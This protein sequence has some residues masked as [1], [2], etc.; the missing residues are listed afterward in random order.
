MLRTYSSQGRPTHD[1]RLLDEGPRA[2]PAQETNR[3]KIDVL[4]ALHVG[5]GDFVGSLFFWVSCTFRRSPSRVPGRPWTA[6]FSEPAIVA[7]ES[8]SPAVDAR[9][10][11]ACRVSAESFAKKVAPS[12]S[13][14]KWI[15][16]FC[17]FDLPLGARVQHGGTEYTFCL[18][19]GSE[20]RR[21]DRPGTGRPVRHQQLLQRFGQ[22][23]D[24]QW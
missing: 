16:V 5:T 17:E 23:S 10:R 8:A 1:T 24:G 6:V 15:V 3:G 2:T 14:W 9:A 19:R 7:R 11:H 20:W 21:Q 22:R 12:S 18:C 13:A 4:E